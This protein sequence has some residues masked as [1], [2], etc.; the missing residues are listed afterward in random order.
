MYTAII[1]TLNEGGNLWFTIHSI[2]QAW[3]SCPDGEPHELI[4]VDGG[5]KD[6]TI[7]FLSTGS[8]PG[9]VKLIQAP[10]TGTGLGRAPGADVARGD[11][12]FFFDAHV[13]VPCDFFRK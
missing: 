8:I 11:V 4:V 9:F 10:T 7:K 6:D 5:S 3:D 12:L 13:L 2:L 1:P